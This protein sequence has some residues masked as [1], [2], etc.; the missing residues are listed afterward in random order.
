MPVAATDAEHPAPPQEL[1]DE[2]AA[3]WTSIVNRMPRDYFAPPTF[4]MLVNLT[5]HVRL[6]RLFA[7][8][9]RDC[10][11]QLSHAHNEQRTQ[12]LR[13]MLA[14]SRAMANE[15]RTLAMLCTRLKLTQLYDVSNIHKARRAFLAD[16]RP[17]DVPN[18]DDE[19]PQ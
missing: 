18:S 15:S 11:A 8:Q 9:L 3:I 2:E 19:L 16:E 5:R 4:P 13:D 6:S 1:N 17:W 7:R 14:L 10:E 12:V